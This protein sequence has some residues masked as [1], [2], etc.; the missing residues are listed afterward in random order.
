[1]LIFF[2]SLDCLNTEFP[3]KRGGKAIFSIFIYYKCV[4]SYG[5]KNQCL[6]EGEIWLKIPL[7]VYLLFGHGDSHPQCPP[8]EFG[9][10]C[11]Q[12]LPVS[13]GLAPLFQLCLKLARL[14]FLCPVMDWEPLS[15]HLCL[16]TCLCGALETLVGSGCLLPGLPASLPVCTCH[17]T[18][19][20]VL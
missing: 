11:L 7:F 15:R 8:I 2:T 10:K 18:A 4:V 1:M 3:H 5:F 17:N 14:R 6:F 20:S 16:L 12:I 13:H 9:D 19:L